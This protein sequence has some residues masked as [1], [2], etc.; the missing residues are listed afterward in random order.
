[1]KVGRSAVVPNLR[2]AAAMARMASGVGELLNKTS[3]PP[4]T[5]RSMNPGASQTSEGS[6]RTSRPDGSSDCGITPTISEPST[7][8]AASLCLVQ[9]SNTWPAAI[10]WRFASFIEFE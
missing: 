9:P 10:A 4:L 6:L 2:W 7:T 1:M 3:P 8:T 5:C